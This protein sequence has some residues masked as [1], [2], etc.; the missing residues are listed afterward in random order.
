MTK[1]DGTYEV[2]NKYLYK[3]NKLE[4]ILKPHIIHLTHK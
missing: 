1:T 2:N 3:I 4:I